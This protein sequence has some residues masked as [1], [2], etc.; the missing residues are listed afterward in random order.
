MKKEPDDQDVDLYE[1]WQYEESIEMATDFIEDYLLPRIAE[2]DFENEETD[3]IPGTAIYTLF[4]RLI[5]I[6]LAAGYEV[7]DLKDCVDEMS[8]FDVMSNTTLH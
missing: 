1:D 2:F 4:M 6:L 8:S 3:Y 7:D 5:P